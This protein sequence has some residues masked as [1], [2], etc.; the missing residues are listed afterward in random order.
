MGHLNGIA[1]L[2]DGQGGIWT[3][4]CAVNVALGVP[5]SQHLPPYPPDLI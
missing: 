2:P 1:Y 5:T 4:I 3:T